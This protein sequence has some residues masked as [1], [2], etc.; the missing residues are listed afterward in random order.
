[1][2]LFTILSWSAYLRSWLPLQLLVALGVNLT[3]SWSA[4]LRCS[5]ASFSAWLRYSSACLVI[6]VIFTSSFHRKHHHIYYPTLQTPTLRLLTI[7]DKWPIFKLKYYPVHLC[8]LLQVVS[9]AILSVTHNFL[10]FTL[11]SRRNRNIAFTIDR[12][13]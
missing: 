2:R 5:S 9:S 3:F 4:C 11:N 1:M 7:Q 6:L 10:P 8:T 13:P 12:E